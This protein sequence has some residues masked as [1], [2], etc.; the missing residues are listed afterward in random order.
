MK[1]TDFLGHISNFARKRQGLRAIL[2]RSA[3][4]LSSLQRIIPDEVYAKKMYKRYTG[5][6]LN[7]EHPRSFNEKLWWLKLNCRNELMTQC[8][9]KYLVRSYVKKCGFEDILT[10]LYGVYDNANQ[11]NFT[12]FSQ[13]VFLKCN[14]GSGTNCIYRPNY[15]FDKK[16]FVSDFNFDLHHNHYVLSREWNYKNI[17]PRILCEEVLR[18]ED[19]SLPLDYKFM[20]FGGVPKLVFMEGCVCD[21]QGRRNTSGSRFVNVYDM[22][23]N[24]MPITSGTKRNKQADIQPPLT[25]SQMKEIAATLSAPFPHCRVDLYCIRGKTYFGEITFYHGGGCVD[26]QPEEWANTMGDWIDIEPI[27]REK[28]G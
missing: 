23:F 20:C 15:P 3:I 18:N 26:I 16:R 19:G 2:H 5:K 21:E 13:E 6:I 24:L 14:H 28:Q 22:D 7:L 1:Y 25:F 27:K 11:V 12:A 8:T 10:Q 4:S 17:R 9:D